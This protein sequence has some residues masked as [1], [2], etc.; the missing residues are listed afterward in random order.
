MNNATYNVSLHFPTNMNIF[1]YIYT[2]FEDSVHF[3]LLSCGTGRNVSC[4]EKPTPPT[5]TLI[6]LWASVCDRLAPGRFLKPKMLSRWWNSNVC[7]PFLWISIQYLKTWMKLYHCDRT[8]L[9]WVWYVANRCDFSFCLSSFSKENQRLLTAAFDVTVCLEI[10]DISN[11]SAN[12]GIEVI[13]LQKKLVHLRARY[14]GIF[15]P[16]LGMI[17]IGITQGLLHGATKRHLT[18]SNSLQ[19]GMTSWWNF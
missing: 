8:T 13:L 19:R 5:Q 6:L 3:P 14:P 11:F 15:I 7:C 1:I 17:I 12:C 4:T 16:H 18:R 10:R 9:W 2:Y